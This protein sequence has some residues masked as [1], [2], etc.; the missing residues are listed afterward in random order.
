[1]YYLINKFEFY[2]LSWIKVDTF[3]SKRN[4]YAS[5]NS[6]RY[7]VVSIKLKK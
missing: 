2:D 3:I 5:T 6:I 1:M 7:D 4:N